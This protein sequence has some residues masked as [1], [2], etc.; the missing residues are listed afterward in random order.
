MP[1]F[2]TAAFQAAALTCASLFNG[3]RRRSAQ[4]ERDRKLEDQ[5]GR[6]ERILDARLP[7]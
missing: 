3:Y 1:D 5:L 7:K 6:I 4:N 2:V